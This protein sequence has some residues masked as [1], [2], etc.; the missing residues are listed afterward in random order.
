MHPMERLRFVAQAAGVDPAVVVAET[1]EAIAHLHPDPAELVTVCRQLVQRNPACGPLWWLSAHLL[2]DGIEHLWD[3]AD[4]VAADPTSELLADALPD[5]ATVVTIGW[6]EIAARALV[7]RG[8][9]AVLGIDAGVGATGLVRMLDRADSRVEAVDPAGLA[10]A[11]AAADLALVEVGVL[12]ADSAVGALGTATLAAA[13][14]TGGTPVWL[15]AGRGCRLPVRFVEWIT[16][17]AIDRA[18]PWRSSFDAV[19]LGGFDPARDVVAGPGGVGAWVPG[20]AENECPDTP[21]LV[22]PVA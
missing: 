5:D 21:E 1:A 15:V 14:R 10:V 12:G 2:R 8:D 11:A 18:A 17:V 20:G 13:A 22:P 19:A 7:R 4:L 9:V 6:P 3:L 16:G